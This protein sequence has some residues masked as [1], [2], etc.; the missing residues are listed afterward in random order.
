MTYP[1]GYQ[2]VDASAVELTGKAVTV[3]DGLM[4]EQLR[5]DKPIFIYGVVSGAMEINAWVNSSTRKGDNDVRVH[6]VN[7]GAT[8]YTI[9]TNDNNVTFTPA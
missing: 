6:H 7:L 5:T 1:G 8:A 2:L 3:E 9:T 4:A